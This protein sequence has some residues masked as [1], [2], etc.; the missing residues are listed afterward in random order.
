MVI[1]GLTGGMASGK[2]TVSDYLKAKR[3]HVIDCDEISRHVLD[4]GTEAYFEVVREFSE[5]IL[6]EDKTVNRKKLSS[7]VFKDKALIEKL[8]GIIHPRVIEQ[9]FEILKRLEGDGADIAVIDAPLLIEAGMD[10]LCKEVWVV[11]APPEI[12]IE[13]AMHRDNSTRE[14]VVEILNNQM[15]F[16]EK[17]KHANRI[18]SNDCDIEHLYSQIDKILQE[19]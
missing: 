19:I 10:K 18:I 11:Y 8:N 13:R 14:Q 5:E 1:I 4:V 7:K 12:Q 3:M 9:T 6:N 15:P 2:S 17:L 16:D